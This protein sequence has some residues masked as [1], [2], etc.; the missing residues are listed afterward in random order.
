MRAAVNY[1]RKG[2]MDALSTYPQHPTLNGNIGQAN[3]AAAKAGVV[4]LTKTCAKENGRKILHAMPL[5]Q[6]FMQ[7]SRT[8]IC[9]LTKTVPT[10]T[11]PEISLPELLWDVLEIR[12]S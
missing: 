7:Q 10:Q 3:Y 2:S 4:A 5:Y 1:M 9:Y 11:E 8:M 6:D 12:R